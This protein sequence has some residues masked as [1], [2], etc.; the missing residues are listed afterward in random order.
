MLCPLL[1]CSILFHVGKFSLALP[2]TDPVEYIDV[3][4]PKRAGGLVAFRGDTPITPSGH[5]LAQQLGK[6]SLLKAC[7]KYQTQGWPI[8]HNTGTLETHFG[9]PEGN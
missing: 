9:C 7:Q 6:S 1:M 8:L 3:D 4:I 5:E 2:F